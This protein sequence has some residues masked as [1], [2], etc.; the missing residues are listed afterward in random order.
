MSCT[1]YVIYK[2]LKSQEL[3]P[4]KKL[5]LVTSHD[6]VLVHCD[7]SYSESEKKG[8]NRIGS[9]TRHEDNFRMT[10]G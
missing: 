8:F 7:I 5:F 9:I 3:D 1:D 10:S 6:F 4:C 2:L